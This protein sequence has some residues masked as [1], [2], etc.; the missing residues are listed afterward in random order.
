MAFRRI[1]YSWNNV[2]KM[3]KNNII[4]GSVLHFYG[5]QEYNMI[6][7]CTHHGVT[8][9]VDPCDDSPGPAHIFRRHVD[10][11]DCITDGTSSVYRQQQP[12]RYVQVL[13]RL[14][15]TDRAQYC[16]N[17]RCFCHS[18]RRDGSRRTP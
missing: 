1:Q 3:E 8:T 14:T 6:V 11:V 15:F 17:V 16:V 4:H 13:F 2:E 10:S 7:Q 5:S 12:H 9:K 18:I